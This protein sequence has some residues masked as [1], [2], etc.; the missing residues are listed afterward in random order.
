M[1]KKKKEKKEKKVS[2]EKP[3]PS[4]TPKKQISSAREKS[5]RDLSRLR[6]MALFSYCLLREYARERGGGGRYVYKGNTQTFKKTM[7]TSDTPFPLWRRSRRFRYLPSLRIWGGGLA[8]NSRDSRAPEQETGVGNL[9]MRFRATLSNGP[10]QPPR[11]EKRSVLTRR[12]Y[13]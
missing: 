8:E 12:R 9:Q 11:C 1:N 7:Q 4:K 10:P 6:H 2:R 5:S 13:A 3:T